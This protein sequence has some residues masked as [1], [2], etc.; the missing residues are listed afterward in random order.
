MR[1]IAKPFADRQIFEVPDIVSRRLRL[2]QGRQLLLRLKDRQVA[3]PFRGILSIEAQ[4]HRLHIH[5]APDGECLTAHMRRGD[6][7]QA[8]L[9][10]TLIPIGR[11]CPRIR[12]QRLCQIRYRKGRLTCPGRRSISCSAG[13]PG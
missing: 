13:L 5:K 4:A 2:Q 7:L 10:G 1:C 6:A 12:A 9:G 8:L 11:S 3:L